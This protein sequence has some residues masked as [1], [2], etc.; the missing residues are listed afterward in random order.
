MGK[1]VLLPFGV[2]PYDLVFQ[3]ETGFHPVQVRTGRVRAGALVFDV[4]TRVGGARRVRKAPDQCI[5]FYAV[6]LPS[7]ETVFLIP[8]A[9]CGNSK[10]QFRLDPPLNGQVLGVRWAKPFQIGA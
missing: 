6:V 2:Q 9:E 5:E 1:T 10:P 3:D 8:A 4:G 7:R